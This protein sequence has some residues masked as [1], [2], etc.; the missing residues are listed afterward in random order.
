[1]THEHTLVI[2]KPVRVPLPGGD[3]EKL[4]AVLDAARTPDLPRRLS[5]HGAEHRSLF[6][7]P[8][9]EVLSDMAP[10]LVRLEPQTALARWVAD[11]GASDSWGFFFTSEANLETLARHLAGFLLVTDEEGS[12]LFFR[13]FDPRVLLPFLASCT[14]DEQRAFMGPMEAL[15]AE[16]AEGKLVRW[17]CPQGSEP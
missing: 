13:F 4:F 6:L 7:G 16:D 3:G 10:Y 12:E 1:M 5:L 11:E 15:W 8:G 14:P 17:T 2:G 9:A